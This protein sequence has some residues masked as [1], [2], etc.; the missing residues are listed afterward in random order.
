[1]EGTPPD[2]HQVRSRLS[3]SASTG[4]HAALQPVHGHGELGVHRMASHPVPSQVRDH[5]RGELR[6][7]ASNRC[8]RLFKFN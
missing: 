8:T 5:L 2:Q 3:A 4:P 1:M 6:H 7:A